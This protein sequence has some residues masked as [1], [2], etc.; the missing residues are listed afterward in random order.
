MKKRTRVVAWICMLV[1]VCLLAWS[2][3]GSILTLSW[4]GHDPPWQTI[5]GW[6]GLVL[7][8]LPWVFLLRRQPWAWWVLTIIY[9]GLALS[10][11]YGLAL[12]PGYWWHRRHDVPAVAMMTAFRLVWEAILCL[13]VFFLLTDRPGGWGK[14]ESEIRSPQ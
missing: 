8:I 2:A 13:P 7:P 3:Y 6:A 11:L 14:A 9:C 1:W 10:A 12:T 4:G 5:L